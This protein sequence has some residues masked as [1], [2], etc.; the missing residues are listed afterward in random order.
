MHRSPSKSGGGGGGGGGGS[1]GKKVAKFNMHNSTTT[2]LPGFL[3]DPVSG[4]LMAVPGIGDVNKAFLERG[5][6]IVT[7]Q[8]KTI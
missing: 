4:D 7:F 3:R 1:S 2:T 8:A 5:K 6:K